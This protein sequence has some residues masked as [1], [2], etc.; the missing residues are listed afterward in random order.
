MALLDI[1]DFSLSVDG[2]PLL[3]AMSLTVD[4]G[5]IVALVGASGSGKSMTA[6]S[7]LGLTPAGARPQGSIH[8]DGRDLTA[9]TDN[10]MDAVRGRDVGLVFQEPMTALNPVLSI[11]AQVAET[12]RVHG[13]T[14]RA[15]AA[16]VADLTLA[17]VG[18]PNERFP[19]SRRP[20]EL[21]GGQRQRVAIAAALAAKPK[22]LI[23]DEPT[24][25]LDVT[26]QARILDLLVDLVRQDGLGLLLISHDLALVS[27][28][29]D[30]VVVMQ[31]G[32][33]VESGPPS[34]ILRSPEHAY[35]RRLLAAAMP[36]RQR[37][38]TPPAPVQPP[39]LTAQDIVRDYTL[40]RPTLW[41]K[42]GTLRAVDR[43]SLAVHRGESV[44]I[45]GESGSGK[46]T[47]LRTLLA[48]DRPQ[49]GTVRLLDQ[50]WS[51]ASEGARRPLRRHVQM[52]FQDPVGSF[53]PR[54]RVERLVAEPLALLDAP[55]SPALRRSRVEELL[56]QVGLAPA[57]ADRYPHEFSGGQRQRIAIAR[58]LA[59][60]PD[61]IAL[62]EATSALDMLTRAQILDL[63]ADLSRRLGLAYLVVSHDLAVV[64]ALTDRL[65]V[66]QDGR[67]VEEG[68]TVQVLSQ[69]RHPYTASLVAATPTLAAQVA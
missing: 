6:L 21:S 63:L 39:L 65:L 46:S 45:V 68:P 26:T 10:Q 13:S 28:V 43:V 22:L 7:V 9:L 2:R 19:R 38:D 11:G 16:R 47:L 59:V 8:L 49:A 3:N 27:R 67:I 69:P 61:L 42:P 44:G 20:H 64:R 37:P 41:A 35:T 66:M 31:D 54:W 25:A 52:V 60:Q 12:V 24:T 34:V 40:P 48:A 14:S 57:D 36:L 56:T 58:A 30:R 33:V 17:R 5:Q 51:A 1:R 15:E 53:D 23:A 50:D 18:L 4:Q 62:D 55:L 32:A 29:A